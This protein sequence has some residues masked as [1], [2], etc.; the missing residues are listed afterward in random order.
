MKT[1][2]STIRRLAA[3]VALLWGASGVLALPPDA[4]RRGALPG[5]LR[6]VGFDQH[7][8][9]P[10]PLDLDF[11]D[12]ADREVRLADYFDQ[13]PVLLMLVYHRCPMLCPMA[14]NGL[15]ASLKPVAFAPG[16]EFEVVVVSIDPTD[17]PAVAAEKK[18]RTL[19]RYGHPETAAGWHFLTGEQE[20][21]TA[22]AS[23]VGFR[24]VYDEGRREYAHAAGVVL[25]TPQGQISRYLF[26]IDLS[27]RDLTLGL[28]ESAAGEIGGPVE[29]LLLLCF[30][31]DAVMGRYSAAALLSVRLGAVLTMLALAV[32]IGGLLVREHRRRRPSVAQGAA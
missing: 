9:E 21:I 1:Q 17:T 3:L 22:L 2:P 20:S 27:P 15:A 10:V 14:L 7:L 28:V 6:E 4:P 29:Q 25:L 12:E 18:Q 8:G 23:A 24:Y 31:Y 32:L 19:E 30:R 16:R 11:R 5:P 26:G 13:R